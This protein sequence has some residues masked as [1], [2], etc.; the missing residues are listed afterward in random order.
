MEKSSVAVAVENG[1]A[2]DVWGHRWCI[3]LVRR[4]YTTVGYLGCRHD[5]DAEA[6]ACRAARRG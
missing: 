3:G 2:L 5:T 6:I 1:W 4:H